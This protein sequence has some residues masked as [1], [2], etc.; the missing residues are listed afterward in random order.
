MIIENRF[1]L[2]LMRMYGDRVYLKYHSD[3]GSDLI[4][5]KGVLLAVYNIIVL[6]KFKLNFIKTFFV[7]IMCYIINLLCFCLL[8]Y[9]FRIDGFNVIY[10]LPLI[11]LYSEICCNKNINKGKHVIFTAIICI[12]T[13]LI[14]WLLFNAPIRIMFIVYII[15]EVILI[16][17][18]YF[19]TK[20][21]MKFSIVKS[22]LFSILAF[23]VSYIAGIMLAC[24][25]DM[26][27]DCIDVVVL[28]EVLANVVLLII[29]MLSS[30][31]IEKNGA[32]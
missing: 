24:I 19:Y 13:N 17:V 10:C 5:T 12:A 2:T 31:I 4:F 8:Y 11:V 29:M 30:R 3:V 14:P 28:F 25:G 9:N 26:V 18:I 27:F 32:Y 1:S 16:P 22:I 7:I 21:M 6:H 15:I 23:G 20:T